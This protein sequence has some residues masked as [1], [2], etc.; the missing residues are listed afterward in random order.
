V[1][2]T[3]RAPCAGRLASWARR[4]VLAQL[5][6]CFAPSL[7]RRATYLAQCSRAVRREPV[8]SRQS[9]PAWSSS[10]LGGTHEGVWGT[11]DSPRLLAIPGNWKWRR[12]RP[13]EG[14]RAN[15]RPGGVHSDHGC[16]PGGVWV[17]S[18]EAKVAQP[19]SN[20]HNLKLHALYY[21]AACS[22]QSL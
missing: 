12:D 13:A 10:P 7:S 1:F 18:Q 11:V 22:Y 5:R 6:P 14:A 20:L 8:Q 15:A 21:S 16:W 9:R 19:A 17:R 4:C 2:G 3:K